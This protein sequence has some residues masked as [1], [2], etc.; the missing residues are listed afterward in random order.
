MTKTKGKAKEELERILADIF[1]VEPYG[2]EGS[3]E[4]IKYNNVKDAE[5]YI[6]ARKKILSW[7]ERE[8]ERM[9]NKLVDQ[10]TDK[11]GQTDYKMLAEGLLAKLKNE[12]N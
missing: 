3:G 1:E 4:V 7:H 11:W 10:C 9:I 5:R 6:E 2:V 12:K 8:V